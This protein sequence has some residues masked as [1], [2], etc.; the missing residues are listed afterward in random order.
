MFKQLKALLKDEN[1]VM[2]EGIDEKYYSD[3]LGHIKVK[4]A[5]V[6]IVDST[7]EVSKILSF[8]N[9]HHIPVVPRGAGTG[10]TG[11]TIPTEDSIVIDL[12]KLNR[13]QHLDRETMTLTVQSGVLLEEVQAFAESKGLFYPPDPGEKASTI[14]GNISTNA[15][16]MRA[17]KY[18]VTRDYVRSIE[19]VLA[20]GDSIELGSENIKDSTGL[21]LKDLLIGSEG[22]LGIITRAK[23][24]LIPKPQI[25]R[26]VLVPFET[27]EEGIDTVLDVKAS[28]VDVAAIEFVLKE[29]ISLSEQYLGIEFPTHKGNAYLIFTFDGDTEGYVRENYERVRALCDQHNALDFL[30]LEDE[31]SFARTWQIRGAIV[32]AVESVSVQ[33]PIDIVVPINKSA[34]FV[35]YTQIVSSRYQV[36]IQSFGHAGDGN[37]HLC[38]IKGTLKDEEWQQKLELVLEDLYQKAA[39]LGGLPS[40][41][42]GIGLTKLKYYLEYANSVQITLMRNLKRAFDKNEILNPNKGF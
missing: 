14:G 31:E 27:L 24:R 26:S 1:R 36:G 28:G 38:I 6:V 40:G 13:I 21:D 23:L 42:H 12:T 41:E 8:A 3:H 15:G 7:D 10:L 32:K 33:E 20:N 18:G 19:V 22:T 35:K 30:V 11:G 16:G 29:T 4:P 39:E 9:T 5:A 25:A 34:E 37:V 2:T 17:V